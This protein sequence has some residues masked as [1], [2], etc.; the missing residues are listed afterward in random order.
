MN[1]EKIPALALYKANGKNT[2]TA[3][4]LRLIP[5]GY[6]TRRDGGAV[7]ITFAA[8]SKDGFDF[9]KGVKCNLGFQDIM[10]VVSVLRGYNSTMNDGHG[11]AFVDADGIKSL[12]L[13]E[14]TNTVGG[15]CFTAQEEAGSGKRIMC[16]YLTPAEAL[17][18]E[19]ALTHALNY[20]VFGV[21]E[22]YPTED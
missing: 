18:I 1:L 5:N 7:E 13:D 4:R 3:M 19:I 21:P 17:G 14:V 2:G 20:I 8:Q 9:T 11:L 16:F 10:A 12:F 22:N 15:F 6:I